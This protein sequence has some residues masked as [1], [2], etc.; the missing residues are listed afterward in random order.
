MKLKSL[1]SSHI[2]SKFKYHSKIKEMIKFFNLKIII[3]ILIVFFLL[4][5]PINIYIPN[6]FGISDTQASN[7]LSVII[8]SLAS[9]LGVLIAVIV[10][11]F[12][13]L[14]KYYNFYAF[15]TFFKNKRL[16][17]FITFYLLTITIA[18]LA[19]I[20]I[21]NPLKPHIINILYFAIFLFIVSLWIL[22][23]YSSAIISS[24]QSKDQIKKIV[25]KID[26]DIVRIY[27]IKSDIMPSFSLVGIEENPIFVLNELG[28]RSLNDNDW[29]TSIYILD[30]CEKKLFDLLDNHL[31]EHG[32]DRE[33]SF[34]RGNI[35][36]VFL[37]IVKPIAYHAI[38]K[39]NES[40]L[41][42]VLGFIENLHYF[43]AQNQ[44]AW[45]EVEDLNN[46]IKNLLK[47]ALSAEL[48]TIPY[49]GFLMVNRILKVHLENNV[50][51]ENEVFTLQYWKAK[52]TGEE[53][54]HNNEKE[55]PDKGVQWKQ[56]STKYIAIIQETAK[57]CVELNNE[58]ILNQAIVSLLNIIRSVIGMSLGDY[59]KY[60]VVKNCCW[61][62]NDLISIKSASNLH[63]SY[64]YLNYYKMTIEKAIKTS[65][66]KIYERILFSYMYSF[67]ALA[68]NGK[69]NS[70][71]LNELG[72]LGI[73][74]ARK[75]DENILYEKSLVLIINLLDKLREMIE[76]QINDNLDVYVKLCDQLIY[77]KKWMKEE[78][79][80]DE[81]VGEQI[82]KVLSNFK[83]YEKIK[84]K[85]ENDQIN[86]KWPYT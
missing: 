62:I 21:S 13:I 9:I 66:E 51:L 78:N 34:E 5:L 49:M 8:G 1:D 54:V 15:R 35:I 10:V 11:A 63:S 52:D 58:E 4:L 39:Q 32:N 79:I 3:A 55:D 19:L 38:K 80:T 29:L 83:D 48:D 42:N 33:K 56:V 53:W 40:V 22:F 16:G 7:I 36:T 65:T 77:L 26:M 70:F 23:P 6:Y 73:E 59:Q 76:E 50:P 17:E 2:L 69:L 68:R 75:K 61:G 64:F 18:F 45:Y 74:F 31:Q 84:E 86:E 60:D 30:V 28:I 57:N 71:E 47:E 85:I 81:D 20:G 41:R 14:R 12:N 44:M 25:N 67:R 24:T 46:F 43:C 37:L 27:K 72:V 82:D